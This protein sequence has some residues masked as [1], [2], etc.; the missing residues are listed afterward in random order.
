MIFPQNVHKLIQDKHKIAGDNK[1]QLIIFLLV[2]GN[3]FGFFALEFLMSLIAPGAPL[4]AVLG[5]QAVLFCLVMVLVFRF[6][7]FDENSKKQEYQGQKSD[8]FTRYMFIQK[9]N[10]TKAQNGVEIFEFMNGS[11]VF[12]LQFR[13][14][15]NDDIKAKG[16][17]DFYKRFM[18]L[19][20]QYGFESRC[21]VGSEDFSTSDEYQHHIDMI[22]EIADV[23]M[24]KTMLTITD[25]IMKESHAHSHV[26]T[27]Y[28]MVHSIYNYQKADLELFLRNLV[29][30]IE[31]SNTAF[32][33]IHFLNFEDLLEL[34]R[35]FYGIAAIDLA[36]MKT[37]SLASD[38]S[39]D[40][41]RVIRIISLTGSSGTVYNVK[42]NLNT[43]SVKERRLN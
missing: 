38:I 19:I 28:V 22:N 6:A 42:K 21:I 3:V 8:S 39:E 35:Y 31:D 17:A 30:L 13:F 36:T 2:I 37:I 41:S 16:T 33:T 4:G 14:G 15:S 24:R 29:N 40:F 34:Y 18:N 7:I 9:D 43:V 23:E 32:R 26:D 25:A 10:V 1:I 11:A 27:V 12:A 5:I 20:S